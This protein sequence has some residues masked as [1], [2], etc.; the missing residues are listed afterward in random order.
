MPDE[1]WKIKNIIGERFEFD[2]IFDICN[3]LR[4]DDDRDI[5]WSVRQKVFLTIKN[6]GYEF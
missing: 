4:L 3:A 5:F 6:N 1:V 2:L